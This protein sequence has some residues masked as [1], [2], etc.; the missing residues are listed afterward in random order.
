MRVSKALLDLAHSF[1]LYHTLLNF[2][3]SECA[4]L[5]L[6][7]VLPPTLHLCPHCAVCLDFFLPLFI[8]LTAPTQPSGLL[9]LP[10]RSPLQPFDCVLIPCCIPL[11][12]HE[13]LVNP[14]ITV[15]ISVTFP[16]SKEFLSPCW[17]LSCRSVGRALFAHCYM[18]GT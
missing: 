9:T 13:L 14:L 5:L 3:C 16:L 6:V 17:T 7:T 1:P 10:L 4:D 18:P 8:W 12:Y 15:V 2:F 11:Y